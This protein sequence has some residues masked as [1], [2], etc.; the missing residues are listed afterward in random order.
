VI[1]LEL[2]NGITVRRNNSTSGRVLRRTEKQRFEEVFVHTN[3]EPPISSSSSFTACPWGEWLAW[4]HSPYHSCLPPHTHQQPENK[5]ADQTL[6][7][8]N[9]VPTKPFLFTRWLP[10]TLVIV[11]DTLGLWGGE[12]YSCLMSF[13]FSGWKVF[14]RWMVIAAQQWEW[15]SRH[16][17]V[18]FKMVRKVNFMLYL[19]YYNVKN[20]QW[21]N[22]PYLLDS[23]IQKT[24]DV[25][26]AFLFHRK[27]KLFEIHQ[28]KGSRLEEWNLPE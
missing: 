14:W 27:S 23:L 15:T 6:E 18:C 1:P 2:K 19:A 12:R 26:L 9:Y 7:S 8:Q 4:P 17:T 16:W 13:R 10:Q 5:S 3:Q 22:E 11:A 24:T 21:T 20:M 25:T 28:V